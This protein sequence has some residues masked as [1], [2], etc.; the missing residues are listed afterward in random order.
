MPKLLLAPPV[1]KLFRIAVET[2]AALG[3]PYAIGGGIAVQVHGYTRETSD[4]D[5]FVLEKN[6]FEV[7]GAL[8]AAGLNIVP[9]ME[10][11]QY[12]A[13]LPEI[14]DPNIRID[15]LIPIDEP[16]LSAVEYGER[17]ASEDITG[18]GFTVFPIDL[19]V[20]AK[21]YA[22]GRRHEIDIEGLLLRGAFNPQKP[23]EILEVIAPDAVA[24]WDALLERLRT[25]KPRRSRPAKRYRKT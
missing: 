14:T 4:V 19:L 5:L 18:G 1:E 15:V 2:T 12:H 17:V 9:F 6:K 21:F 8:H 3:V 20:L 24:E 11:S 23:R 22:T 16:E 10:P 25:P 7:L 13:H